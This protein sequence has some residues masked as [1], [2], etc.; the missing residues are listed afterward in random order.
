[1]K[2]M[3]MMVILGVFNSGHKKSEHNPTFI[4]ARIEVETMKW[5]LCEKKI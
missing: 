1:M 3:K 2:Q 5:K 4:A